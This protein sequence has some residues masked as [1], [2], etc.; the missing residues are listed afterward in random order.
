MDSTEIDSYS[1]DLKN[2]DEVRAIFAKY[3]KGGIWG[4]I[5]VAVRCF[6]L[7]LV[8]AYLINFSLLFR[9]TKR[10]GSLRKS[11]LYIMRITSVPRFLSFKSCPTSTVPGWSIH[12]PQ[13]YMEHLLTSLSRS[14]HASKLI[15][16]TG[17]QRSCPRPSLKISAK[18]SSF[19][20]SSWYQAL[21]AE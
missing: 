10:S 15:V 20:I 11:H 5:H 9:P 7:L 6:A 17:D 14:Q 2:G 18:A 4:V 1:C 13:L 16:L 3:G 21:R 12:L 8:L 19:H